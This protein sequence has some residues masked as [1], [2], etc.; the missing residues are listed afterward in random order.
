[1]QRGMA[2]KYKRVL[3]RGLIMQPGKRGKPELDP[4]TCINN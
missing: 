2:K 1:M 3:K 4:K